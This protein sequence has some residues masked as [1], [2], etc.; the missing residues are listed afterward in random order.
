MTSVERNNIRPVHDSRH[1]H[2]PGIVGFAAGVVAV[3]LVPVSQ[4]LRRELRKF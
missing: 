3:V 2:P 4:L 1:T